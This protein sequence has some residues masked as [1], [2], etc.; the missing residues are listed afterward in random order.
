MKNTGLSVILAILTLIFLFYCSF[1][2]KL[3]YDFNIAYVPKISLKIINSINFF[4]YFLANNL[5][6][7]IIAIQGFF[8]L[9]TFLME[10]DNYHITNKYTIWLSY[11]AS[12]CICLASVIFH[13]IYIAGFIF[14]ASLLACFAFIFL[15][16]RMYN[17]I[18]LFD[19][20]FNSKSFNKDSINPFRKH[21]NFLKRFPKQFQDS[22]KGF[23][24]ISVETNLLGKKERYINF[25]FPFRHFIIV[26]GPGGGKSA[27]VLKPY[28]HFAIIETDYTGVIY[29][30]KSPELT[31]LSY[32]FW[33]MKKK[34]NPN[35]K[36]KFYNLNFSDPFS[37]HQ[38]N[39]LSPKFLKD[40]ALV[41]ELVSALYK[42]LNKEAKDDF[43]NLGA[44]SYITS[45]IWWLIKKSNQYE[46]N[47]SNFL[48]L[49]FAINSEY[50]LR[51]VNILFQDIDTKADMGMLK[52]A[53][54][55][56][57]TFAGLK[58]ST[59][60]ALA[61]LNDKSLLWITYQDGIDINVNHPDS[62]AILC[63]GNNP[64][65]QD[66]YSPVIS[67]AFM[68]I[69]SKIN[70]KERLPCAVILDELPTII[71]PKLDQ[72]MN[73]GRSNKISVMLAFQALSQLR[74]SYDQE[75]AKNIVAGALNVLY[76]ASNELDANK[77]IS[78]LMG[79]GEDEKE[80]KSVGK[81][82]SKSLSREF[83][84]ILQ[85]G[86]VAEFSAGTFA[87]I[88]SGGKL[89]DPHNP[90]NN[91]FIASFKYWD[92]KEEKSPELPKT[93][94]FPKE[95]IKEVVFNEHVE[96]LMI[97]GSQTIDN[98]ILFEHWKL[99]F[100]KHFKLY[101]Q[102]RFLATN[103][104]DA[105][106][107]SIISKLEIALKDEVKDVFIASERTVKKYIEVEFSDL[108]N[109]FNKD[110]TSSSSYTEEENENPF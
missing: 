61:K 74:K 106:I 3:I 73:T 33:L 66:T 21:A 17:H 81:D 52:D 55:S 67:L 46:S 45:C 59:S 7:W 47:Y 27:S 99:F 95:K 9:C 14:L 86:E 4:P 85:P 103:F 18:K 68:L 37:S 28:I 53:L 31:K 20:V 64:E 96:K 49:I 38:L 6:L 43:W 108:L 110:K 13:K 63:I 89:D 11:L 42:N 10:F 92:Y 36:H 23:T 5:F 101:E 71:L 84:D 30:Y 100:D 39:P 98:L 26:A 8:V 87:G 25:P 60:S 82:T 75:E 16:R 34:A 44:K 58:S 91:K 83:Y 62:P 29:D 65:K 22:K 24:L 107:K 76:G 70:V 90:N 19:W 97:D 94:E 109:T 57:N 105:Y 40:Y 102:H 1:Y 104:T 50:S 48:H 51:L 78:E 12:L 72:L 80:S 79:K 2:F 56:E 88:S 93:L 15:I 69:F 77:Q 41:R 35:Y 32:K 54:G